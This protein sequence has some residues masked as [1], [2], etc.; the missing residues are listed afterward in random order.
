MII[1]RLKGGL[2]NQLF[3]YALGRALSSKGHTVFFDCVTGFERDY[4]YQRSFELD[5]L[6]GKHEQVYFKNIFCRFFLFFIFKAVKFT[7]MF[8]IENESAKLDLNILNLKP[9]GIHYL[10]GYWFSEQYFKDILPIIKWELKDKIEKNFSKMTAYTPKFDIVAVHIRIYNVTTIEDELDQYYE[11]LHKTLKKIG[12]NSQSKLMIFTN[13]PNEVR[14]LFSTNFPNSSFSKC[15]LLPIEDMIKIS[16]YKYIIG[17]SS[18]YS[19]W[20]LLLSEM[21]NSKVCIPTVNINHNEYKWGFKGLIP[22]RWKCEA[23]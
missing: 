22:E 19:W 11:Y 3:G 20:S 2:G 21:N 13:L 15:S 16:K 17:S 4:K 10:D 1:I 14:G 9:G 18:T 7:R 8:Y 12:R 5:W 6:I 23:K